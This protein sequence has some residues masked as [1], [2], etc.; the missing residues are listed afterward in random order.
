MPALPALVTCPHAHACVPARPKWTTAPPP[1]AQGRLAARG[2]G[3]KQ[4]R[5][6]SSRRTPLPPRRRHL[7]SC[8]TCWVE[9]ARQGGL[10]Q[11]MA[12]QGG[13]RASGASSLPA[14]QVGQPPPTMLPRLAVSASSEPPPDYPALFP[15][16]CCVLPHLVALIPPVHCCML[17]HLVALMLP[18]DCCMLP[19]LVAPDAHCAG[20]GWDEPL[21]AFYARR[22]PQLL[23][24]CSSTAPSL[25]CLLPF[26]LPCAP[27]ATTCPAA[28]PGACRVRRCLVSYLDLLV[29]SGGVDA[30]AAA[31]VAE[32]GGGW[33]GEAY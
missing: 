19:H 8:S 20:N 11:P 14:W 2:T 33:G 24:A 28:P 21:P 4:P 32:V 26:T 13:R 23:P 5:L 10:A 17:P 1:W 22:A 25:L 3:G 12:Q 27:P 15:V 31:G 9:V 30:L 6:A 18:M 29:D 7:Q 16:E